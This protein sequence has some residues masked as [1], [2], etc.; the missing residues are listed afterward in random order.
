MMEAVDSPLVALQVKKKKSNWCMKSVLAKSRD[1][2]PC[3]FDSVA[4][5]D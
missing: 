4:V 1:L 3:T 2:P 5:R